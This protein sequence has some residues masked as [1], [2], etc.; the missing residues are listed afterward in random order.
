MHQA[1]HVVVGSP[2]PPRHVIHNAP[3]R[4]SGDVLETG[5]KRLA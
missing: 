4:T 2:P 5:Q 3:S 1:A